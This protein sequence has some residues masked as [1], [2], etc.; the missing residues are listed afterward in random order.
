MKPAISTECPCLA[1]P[2]L[3]IALELLK[4]K[5]FTEEFRKLTKQAVERAIAALN[6]CHRGFDE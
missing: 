2:W 1:R 6:E 5:P 3:A 4:A